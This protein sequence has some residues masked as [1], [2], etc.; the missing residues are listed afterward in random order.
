MHSLEMVLKC[1]IYFQTVLLVW[2][3]VQDSKNRVVCFTMEDG[4]E[5]QGR[6]GSLKYHPLANF[7]IQFKNQLEPQQLQQHFLSAHRLLTILVLGDRKRKKP[8]LSSSHRLPMGP[9][10]E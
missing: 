6:T 1:F 2:L 4:Q 3:L 8:H 9:C 5:F 7:V 10:W